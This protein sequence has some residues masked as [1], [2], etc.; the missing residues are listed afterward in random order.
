LEDLPAIE[1]PSANTVRVPLANVNV[2]DATVSSEEKKVKMAQA[3]VM[4]GFNP[5]EALAA[6][7]L[8]AIA[9][10]GLATVQL[11]G[12]AQVNPEDPESVYEV[13]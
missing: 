5:A 8:P 3:L 4:V 1:N 10:T 12:V 6:M 9:H 2:E 11:Q 7:G 13:E